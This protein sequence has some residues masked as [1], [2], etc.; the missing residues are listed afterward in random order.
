VDT[1]QMLGLSISL[2]RILSDFVTQPLTINKEFGLRWQF[3]HV[4]LQLTIF[5]SKFC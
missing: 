1:A 3:T 2:P 4:I 5:K